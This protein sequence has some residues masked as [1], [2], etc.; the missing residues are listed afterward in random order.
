MD[1]E[2]VGN[3]FR[4]WPSVRRGAARGPL[5]RGAWERGVLF[6]EAFSLSRPR[7]AFQWHSTFRLGLTTR[8]FRLIDSLSRKSSAFWKK[9]AKDGR[10][11]QI[12]SGKRSRRRVASL[13]NREIGRVDRAM[14]DD[15]FVAGHVTG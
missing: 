8:T 10:T 12:V 7:A 5:P 9:H 1:G 13:P 15:P 2:R 3:N 4:H 14:R 11:L 6:Q